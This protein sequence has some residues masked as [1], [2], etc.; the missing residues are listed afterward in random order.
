VDIERISTEATDTKVS[1][2]QLQ[3][4]DL[5]DPQANVIVADTRYEDHQ[6][7]SI[8]ERLRHTLGLIRIS[9]NRVLYEAPVPKPKG[10]R[11]APRKH[12]HPFQLSEPARSE[13]R[14]E[15]FQLGKQTVQS[16]PGTTCTSRNSPCW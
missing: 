16:K 9:S 11:G 14:N 10:S 1:A 15:M 3:E 6:F 7:L 5:R 2:V 12:C 13:N 4:L 8:F